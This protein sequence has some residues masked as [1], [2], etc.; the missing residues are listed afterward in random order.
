[1]KANNFYLSGAAKNKCN[2][3]SLTEDHEMASLFSSSTPKQTGKDP[4]TSFAFKAKW[5]QY[6]ELTLQSHSI[7]LKKILNILKMS[8]HT[9]SHFLR[10]LSIFSIGINTRQSVTLTN[11]G[12]LH[13]VMILSFPINAIPIRTVTQ[14]LDIHMNHLTAINVVHLN[15]SPTLQAITNSK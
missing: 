3:R 7:L 9:F 12:S 8:M 6:L 10:R 1:M 2:L 5:D 4:L 11:I 15:Q 13:L 14:T